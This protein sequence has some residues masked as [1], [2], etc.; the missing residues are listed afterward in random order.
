MSKSRGLKETA[1]MLTAYAENLGFTMDFTR[2]GHLKFF[3]AG[4]KPVFVSSTPSCPRAL[5]NAQADLRRA[6]A[7]SA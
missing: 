3:K 2:N 5:K 7:A 1:R 6:A 4:A